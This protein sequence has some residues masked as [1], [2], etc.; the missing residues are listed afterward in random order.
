MRQ[1]EHVSV[2]KSVDQQL[3]KQS[4][5]AQAEARRCLTAIFTSIKFLARQGLAFRG[6]DDSEGN[7]QQLLNLRAL[8]MPELKQWLENKFD[9]T[10]PLLQNEMLQLISNSIVRSI[11]SSVRASGSFA[12]IVDGTQD[13]SKK[14]QLSICLRYVDEQLFP[15]QVF[16]GMYEPPTTTGEDLATSVQDVLIRLQ[17]PI[18]DLRGQTYDG[19]SN[20]SGQYKGCQALINQKQPLALYVHCGAHCVNLIAQTVTEAVVP[21]RD[22]VHS[23]NELGALFSQSIKCRTAFQKIVETDHDLTKLKQ[24]RPI[25]PTRWLVRVPAIVAVI[26]QYASILQCLEEISTA[27][28]GSNVAARASGAA[29]CVQCVF[30]SAVLEDG[31]KDTWSTGDAQQV[32]SVKIP[33]CRWDVFSCRRGR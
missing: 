20:M 6:H 10:S 25:C 14:E 26:D 4:D 18:A 12:V 3:S 16:V 27:K 21:V 31:T 8:D 23:L 7:I 1:V 24:I 15:H 33:N 22:A 28:S 5:C 2:A 19:A 11:A 30:H 9:Y 17:L 29:D 13:V 32:S